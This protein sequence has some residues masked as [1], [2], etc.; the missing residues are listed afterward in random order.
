MGI[1]KEQHDKLYPLII[2]KQ[3]GEYCLGCG[4]IPH[5]SVSC[6]DEPEG[7]P[8]NS[9]LIPFYVTNKDKT[10]L[11]GLI[12]DHVDRDTNHNDL[13]NLQLL[14]RT[15]NQFKDPRQK[16]KTLSDREKSPE[17]ARGDK[18]EDRYRSWLNIEVTVEHKH[19]FI[20]EDEAIYGGAE[21]LTDFSLGETISPVTTRRYLKKLTTSSGMYYWY[22]GFVGMKINLT[23]LEE[24]FTEVEHEK[25]RKVKKINEFHEAYL[26]QKISEE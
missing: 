26:K 12:I 7:I 5:E 25:R 17:M 10:R 18:Q 15:C 21:A 2:E 9:K 3:H 4:A 22:K 8:I 20:S 19:K 23:L 11:L 13:S 14:C 6:L 1:N 16:K 24:W